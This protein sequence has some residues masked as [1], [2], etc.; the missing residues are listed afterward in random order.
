MRERIRING[1]PI[2]E[3]DFARYFY[4]V[5]DELDKNN[6][7]SVL[8]AV[9]TIAHV[10]LLFQRAHPSTS[11]KPA[12]FRFVTLVAFHAFLSLKVGFSIS[13]SL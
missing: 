7:V 11:L 5:W 8:F 9:Y 10:L 4:E 6:V 1:V 13:I 3:E 2:S 12:Y